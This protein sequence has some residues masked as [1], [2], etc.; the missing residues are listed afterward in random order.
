MQGRTASR[1]D[2]ERFAALVDLGCVVCRLYLR[3][4]TPPEIHH[5]YGKTRVGAHQQTIPLCYRHHRE[6]SDCKA[7]TSRHPHRARFEDRYGTEIE[8]LEMTNTLLAK[9]A[10]L[11]SSAP[12]LNS[13]P[14]GH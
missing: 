4:Y 13:L 7:Y 9:I 12:N 3:I 1:A 14:P 6:G 2:E 5:L 10:D 8:L 11:Q